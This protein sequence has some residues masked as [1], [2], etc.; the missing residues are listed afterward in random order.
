MHDIFGNDRKLEKGLEDCEDES[1]FDAS[2]EVL[3]QK[4][5]TLEKE[6]HKERVP[7]LSN[8]FLQNVKEDT[9][10]GML[11]PVRREI[12]LGSGFFLQQCFG[13]QS[14]QV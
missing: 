13:M 10:T 5:D 8:Y 14:L 11:P 12:G 7:Q 4:W 1:Q 6:T 3:A 2:M 9:K